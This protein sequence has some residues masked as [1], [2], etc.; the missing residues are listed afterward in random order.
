MLEINQAIFLFFISYLSFNIILAFIL[1]YSM[2]EVYCI[3]NS[4]ELTSIFMT[5]FLFC[6]RV[7]EGP[8]EDK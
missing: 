4:Q 1:G 6:F 7:N 5:E 3:Y 2:F 8:T